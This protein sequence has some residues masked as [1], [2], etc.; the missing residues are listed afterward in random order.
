METPYLIIFLPVLERIACAY[1]QAVACY[2]L[3]ELEGVGCVEAPVVGETMG[4]AD[5]QVDARTAGIGATQTHAAK[6]G[7]GVVAHHVAHKAQLTEY[8]RAVAALVGGT[9]AELTTQILHGACLEAVALSAV[10][11]EVLQPAEHAE[12][13]L[14]ADGSSPSQAGI[15]L[16]GILCPLVGQTEHIQLAFRAGVGAHPAQRQ[17]FRE[18]VVAVNADVHGILVHREGGEGAHLAPAVT[19]GNAE[20]GFFRHAPLHTECCTAEREIRAVAVTI[21]RNTAASTRV[22][23][24]ERELALR[25]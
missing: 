20:R 23:F 13:G 8:Q 16:Q 21:G 2:I 25:G 4:G 24:D 1:I 11:G 10:R 19:N 14:V 5:T 18:R 6:V 17:A 3:H 22:Y 12:R 7:G 9:D 15:Q